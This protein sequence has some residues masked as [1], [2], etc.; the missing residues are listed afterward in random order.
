MD[1]Y[2]DYSEEEFTERHLE[3]LSR[4]SKMYAKAKGD[5]A[6]LEQQRKH[7]KALLMQEAEKKGASSIQKQE[8][9]AYADKRFFLIAEAIG[10]AQRTTSQ[11]WYDYDIIKVK[12]EKWRTERA[13]VRAAANLR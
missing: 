4:L 12:F 3:E 11:A 8:R 13:D 1:S 6:R 10:V 9:D 7:L 5:L 2:N